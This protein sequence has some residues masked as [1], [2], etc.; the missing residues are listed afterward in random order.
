MMS[1]GVTLRCNVG[2]LSFSFCWLFRDRIISC[3]DN[4]KK[5]ALRYALSLPT[6][7]VKNLVMFGLFVVLSVGHRALLV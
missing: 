4:K 2:I 3:N 7:V 1:N 6:G 5:V